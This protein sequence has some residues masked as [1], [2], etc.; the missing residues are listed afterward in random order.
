MPDETVVAK[1]HESITFGDISNWLPVIVEA[2][3][4]YPQLQAAKVGDTVNTPSV[5]NLRVA[6]GHFDAVLQLTKRS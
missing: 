3:Q 2:L 5:P 4:V 1:E 6:H